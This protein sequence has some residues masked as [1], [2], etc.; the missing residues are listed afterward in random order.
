VVTANI[1]VYA[2]WVEVIPGTCTVTFDSKGG[3]GTDPVTVQERTPVPQPSDPTRTGYTFAG[4]YTVA[5]DTPFN[6][7]APITASTAVYA[8]WT[9]ILCTVTF[10]PNGG[11]LTGPSPVPVNH[12]DTITPSNPTRI[13]HTFSGWQDSAGTV[14]IAT[15]PVTADII[16]YAQ[17]TINRYTVIFDLSGGNLSGDITN[18][19]RTAT[20][21]GTVSL[22]SVPPTKDGHI[23][24][25]WA[26]GGDSS[27]D[28]QTVVT[29]DITVY[30]QWTAVVL[31][32]YTV[33]FNADGGTPGT[34]NV[35]TAPGGGTVS[36]PAVLKPGYTFG[37]W[38]TMANGGGTAFT[39]ATR[40]T[41]N[42][43]VYAKWT[44]NRYTVTFDLKG[45]TIGSSTSNPT[46]PATLN[47]TE[48]ALPVPAKLGHTF[49]GWYTAV[50]GGG[51]AFTATTSVTADITVYAKWTRIIV[52]F[53]LS[54]GNISGDATNPTQT[55]TDSG[56]VSL[57]TAPRRTG[58][59][60]GGWYTAANGS[61]DQFD[62][63]TVVM[64]DITVYAKW[65][66]VVLGTYTVTFNAD[67]GTP[68]TTNVS[69]APGGGTVSLPA[70]LKPGYTFGGWYTAVNGGGDQFDEQTVVMA[71]IPV[72]AKWTINSYTVTFDGNGGTLV[73]SGTASANYNT[74]LGASSM[75][76][77]PTPPTGYTFG[78]WN[79]AANGT[80]TTF[81]ATTQVMADITVYAKWTINSYTVTF[82]DNGGTLSGSG[83]ASGTILGTSMP[84]APTRTG[85]TFEGWYTATTGGTQFTSTTPVT[86]G[87]TVYARWTINSHTVTFNLSGGN[88]GGVTTNPTRT[89]TYGG[90]VSSL[91]GNP[92]KANNIFAGW[93]TAA[94]GG[95]A[96]NLATVI[97]ADT[98]VYAQWTPSGEGGFTLNPPGDVSITF[99]I[100]NGAVLSKTAFPYTLSA[101]LPLPSGVTINKW[102][103]DGNEV[104]GVTGTS[105]TLSEAAHSSYG[106]HTVTLIVRK[107]AFS[108]AA[109]FPLRWFLDEK[110]LWRNTPSRPDPSRCGFLHVAVR[111]RQGDCPRIERLIA[112]FLRKRRSPQRR[113]QCAA[114]GCG[115]SS[116][117]HHTP[118][119]A[120]L[121]AIYREL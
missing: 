63:Q 121:C 101:T 35:S 37:G 111:L 78:N 87:I 92:T 95:T 75:P 114:I 54:G 53:N 44:I 91:P 99:N 94:T 106:T 86:A 33:T 8:K 68:G 18:P 118:A 102:L 14:F 116:P 113:P 64:A 60:F 109:T 65:T 38:Y 119:R 110:A 59:T 36:L 4:W 47:G 62:G 97:T 19:T 21:G 79:T 7:D 93:Y 10:E 6:F 32:T 83:T 12:G 98:D 16:V 52:T 2:K 43:T 24:D 56:T 30:A 88:I 70:V 29:A 71:N 58:Y 115:G 103:V 28:G 72:Y 42:I 1:T 41:G 105:L 77:N 40:V 108:I 3:S 61:G 96:F 67:G 81:T 11:T 50:N 57:P 82:N 84:A 51:T 17:W 15:T 46:Q 48:S 25:G 117:L 9:R 39:A 45:G 112:A 80:G 100:E 104:T 20:H 76:A 73:G 31:G 89:A 66:A 55:A 74:A 13:G 69:T 120:E 22:P 34:T 107:T 26:D 5:T 27:F 85:Y 49:G 23:F 90:T